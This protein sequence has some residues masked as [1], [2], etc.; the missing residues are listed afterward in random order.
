MPR[1]V[2]FPVN[3]ESHQKVAKNQWDKNGGKKFSHTSHP[4]SSLGPAG[5]FLLPGVQNNSSIVQLN[6]DA[7]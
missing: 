2:F 1:I 3:S 4:L 6:N 7:S 5:G